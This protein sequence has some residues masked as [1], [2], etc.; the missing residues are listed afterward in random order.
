M[1][2]HDIKFYVNGHGTHMPH[3]ESAIRHVKNKARSV[4]HGLQFP[5]PSKL[6]AALLT[7]VV[8][9][10]NMVPKINSPGHLPA[11]TAFKGRVPNLLIDAPYPFGT[12][13]FLQRS[14]GSPYNTSIPRGDC[15]L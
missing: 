5:V 11:F 8:A 4:Q 9:T 13:G 2:S 6:A 10:I 12:S 3:A 15:C 7:F 14:A 1:H